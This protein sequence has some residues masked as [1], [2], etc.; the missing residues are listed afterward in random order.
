MNFTDIMLLENKA[1]YTAMI[2]PLITLELI[3]TRDAQEL[4]KFVRK[5]LKR[6]DRIVW[7]LKWYRILKLTD[8][9]QQTQDNP[10]NPALIKMQKMLDKATKMPG[11]TNPRDVRAFYANFGQ[12]A[13][14]NL[15]HYISMM[16]QV[17]AMDN[18]VWDASLTPHL[19]MRELDK[20]ESEWQQAAKQ[21]ID[22]DQYG[23]PN[24]AGRSPWKKVIDYGEQA[25]V[26]IDKDYCEL[27]GD[28][29]GHC[30]NQQG[31]RDRGGRILSFRTIINDTRQ[32]PHLTFII[33]ADGKLGEMKGRAN[34]KP[35]EK[36]HKVIVDLL[37]SDMVTGITGGGHD[38]SNNFSVN[39]LSDEMQETLISKKP[40]FASMKYKVKNGIATNDD[41]DALR[42]EFSA[43]N[44]GNDADFAVDISSNSVT[45][46]SFNDMDDI[47]S[48]AGVFNL[49]QLKYL[50]DTVHEGHI[51]MYDTPSPDSD[52]MQTLI[53][54]LDREM[55]MTLFQYVEENMADPD[56]YHDDNVA[57]IIIEDDQLDEVYSA[58][59]RA[60]TDA[61][62]AGTMSEMYKAL[63]S[64]LKN[65]GIVDNPS[66]EGPYY[67]I[68]TSLN[69]A[70]SLY[71][72]IGGDEYIEMDYLLETLDISDADEL[73]N[74]Y[75][76]YDEEAG[77]ERLFDHLYEI[78]GIDEIYK[79]I[80][81]S[82]KNESIDR[83]KTLAGIK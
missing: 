44:F 53:D 50:A 5:N 21:E 15:N 27:E 6:N 82:T 65:N 76:G 41:F 4:L 77:I 30:G 57:E 26:L 12:D 42:E 10:E 52:E 60:N 13:R 38:P 54:G 71:E 66:K 23:D 83:I 68:T 1:Q 48:W 79:K 35:A 40:V 17:P 70:L 22:V 25:W 75:Y 8:G 67:L 32:K 9:I 16:D 47:A 33:S 59:D 46:G 78:D 63:Q 37:L 24:Y 28:A 61:M 62:E 43:Y 7:W 73:R 56:D 31:G 72:E 74:G 11:S 49:D 80:K 36:Y 14:T 39:E 45:L 64:A 81:A 58:F 55:T 3:T 34:E 20:K 2:Q 18:I 51:E 19:L 69:E 29:M